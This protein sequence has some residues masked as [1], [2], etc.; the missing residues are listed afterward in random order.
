M[1]MPGIC[2]AELRNTAS[3]RRWSPCVPVLVC[4]RLPGILNS[5]RYENSA[6][7]VTYAH[8]ATGSVSPRRPATIAGRPHQLVG[9][10][11]LRAGTEVREGG[12][13]RHEGHEGGHTVAAAAYADRRRLT[14][15][16]PGPLS[17]V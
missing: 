12:L 11:R 2:I 3:V 1:R 10:A 8:T 4:D 13:A 6:Y 5:Y 7:A 17:C 9:E 16:F 14:R 15:R